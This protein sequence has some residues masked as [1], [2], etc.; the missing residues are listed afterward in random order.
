MFANFRVETLASPMSRLHRIELAG[1]LYHVTSR[2]DRREDIYLSDDD[3]SAWLDI[4]RAVC[5]RFQ[6]SC[7]GWCRTNNHFRAVIETPA[8]TLSQGMRQLNGVYT[9][10]VNRTHDRVGHAF[11]GRFKAIL[12][13]RD[14]Y[15]LELARYVVLNP[16]RARMVK[17]PEQWGCSSYRAMIGAADRSTSLHTDWI[18]GQFAARRSRAGENYAEFVWAGGGLSSIWDNLRNQIFLGGD[19]FIERLQERAPKD[20][21]LGEIPRIKRRQAAKPLSVY[22]AAGQAD[23]DVAIATAFRSCDYTMKQL[24]E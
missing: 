17:R 24:A 4:L 13:E 7:H 8:G 1:G 22:E 18:V 16:V 12:V 14:A 6:W 2:G 21:D 20:T 3:R 23:R 9:Q 11:Q 19:A 5:R 10:Y 15:L